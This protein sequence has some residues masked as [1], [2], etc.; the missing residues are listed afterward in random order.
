MPYGARSTLDD[1]TGL[2]PLQ[3]KASVKVGLAQLRGVK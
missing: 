2:P 1:D 3:I